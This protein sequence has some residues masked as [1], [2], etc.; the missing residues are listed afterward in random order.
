MKKANDK[1]REQWMDFFTFLWG[2]M[3]LGCKRRKNRIKIYNIDQTIDLLLESKK[4]IARFGDGEMALIRGSSIRFQKYNGV[5][6]RRL[7]EVL[8]SDQKHCFV[9]ITPTINKIWDLRPYARS[10]WTENMLQNYDWWIANLKGTQYCTANI[11]RPYID[12]RNRKNSARWFYKLRKL[13]D[14]RKIVIVEGEGTRFGI[15][16]KLVNNAL[17]IKRIICPSTNAFDKYDMILEVIKKYDKQHLILLALG[18]TAT[19]MAYDLAQLG[20]QAI[21]IGHCDLEFEWFRKKVKDKEKVKGKFTNE[22]RGGGRVENC[23]SRKYKEQIAAIV[24]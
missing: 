1:G 23:N 16:N 18:P 15:G 5:L 11:T 7:K 20:Y 9:G 21:D 13:W 2:T 14:G 6:A 8:A 22:V 24:K 10:F 17:E 19:V 4:S 12:Y 3:L